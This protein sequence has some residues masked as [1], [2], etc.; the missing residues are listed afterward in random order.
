MT[1]LRPE[2]LLAWPLIGLLVWHLRRSSAGRWQQHI[3]RALLEPLLGNP[4]DRRSTLVRGLGMGALL[5]L[6]LALAG[7]AIELRSEESLQERPA[8]I[9]LD[10]SPTMLTTDISPDRHTRARQKIQDWLAANPGR[11]AALVAYSGTAHVVTP[12]TFDHHTLNTM[13]RQLHPEMMPRPGSHPVAALTLAQEQLAGQ[14]GDLLWLTDSLSEAQRTAL[15]EFAPAV[16]QLG[17]IVLGS[18][19]GAP[20]LRRDGTPLQD[21]AGNPVEPVLDTTQFSILAEQSGIQWHPVRPDDSDWQTVLSEGRLRAGDEHGEGQTVTRDLGHWLLI[22]LLPGLL[23]LYGRGQLLVL[24][25]ALGLTLSWSPAQASGLDWLRSPDQQGAARLPEDPAAAM[26]LFSSRDW[27][28]YAALEAGEYRRAL[29]WLE[30]PGNARDHYHRGNALVHLERFEEALEAYDEALE[31]D[32]DFAEAQQNRDL[33]ARFLERLDSAGEQGEEDQA[34]P[35]PADSAGGGSRG[36]G[37]PALPGDSAGDGGL[38]D[39]GAQA[40]EDSIRQRLPEPDAGFLERKFLYQY[41]AEPDNVDDTGPT[42]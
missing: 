28:I 33:L 1:L 29:E 40:L 10:L 16:R 27:R 30:P 39:P 15:P 13:L 23:I 38:T 20:A 8:V 34:A 24:P 5:L 25:L 3:D 22:A 12:L 21:G 36:D 42:W 32:S 7:P 31:L 9:I 35:G 41:R 18:D 37:S 6:P 4:A 17:I 11:P 19:I 14:T 26:D 2:W